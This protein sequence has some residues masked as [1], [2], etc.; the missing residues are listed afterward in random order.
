MCPKHLCISTVGT[1]TDLFKRDPYAVLVTD[2]FGSVRPVELVYD[3]SPDVF[4]VEKPV[5]ITLEDIPEKK[6]KY[7]YVPPFPEVSKL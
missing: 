5:N 1:R 4:V 3:V 2:F 6:T 7:Y